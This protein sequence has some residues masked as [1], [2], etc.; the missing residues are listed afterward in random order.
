[1]KK[2]ILNIS[3]DDKEILSVGQNNMIFIFENVTG[4]EEE[5]YDLLESKKMSIVEIERFVNSWGGSLKIVTLKQ[6]IN[7]YYKNL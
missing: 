3:S 7:C 5:I 6:L 1:M 2:L 4:Y